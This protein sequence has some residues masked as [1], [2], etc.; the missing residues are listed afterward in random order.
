MKKYQLTVTERQ[1]NLIAECVEDCHR[2]MAGQYE[3]HNMT[4]RLD[5]FHEIQDTLKDTKPLVTPHISIGASY[6]WNGGS[7]PNEYQRKFIAETYPIYREIYHFL[8]IERGLDNT[9]SSETLTCE[10]GGK[11]IQIKAL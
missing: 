10:E 3:L 11:P 7:C 2:F 1:L 9:Y 4:S 6:G 5:A 8:T